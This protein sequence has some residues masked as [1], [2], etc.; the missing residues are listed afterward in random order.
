MKKHAREL[1]AEEMNK[2]DD[3]DIDFSD[4]A[5]LDKDFWYNAK[6]ITPDNTTQVTLRV[7]NPVLNYFKSSGKG[8]QT[9]INQVLE[10]YIRS[11]TK[12]QIINITPIQNNVGQLLNKQK[13]I[14]KKPAV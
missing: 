10:S 12:E 11:Q 6:L 14:M 3:L 4:I 8:Y 13:H 2:L 9:P 5:K 1:T 7:K